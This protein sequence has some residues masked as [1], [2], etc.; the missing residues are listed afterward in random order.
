M[1]LPFWVECKQLVMSS[2]ALVRKLRKHVRTVHK[3]YYS[4]LAS[5]DAAGPSP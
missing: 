3:H 5:S 1:V 4:L 2:T